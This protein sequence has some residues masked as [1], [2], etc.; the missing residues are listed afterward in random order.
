MRERKNQTNLRKTG[1]TLPSIPF[2][3][4][5]VQFC[6]AVIFDTNN[7]VGNVILNRLHCLTG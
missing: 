1:L 7:S 2:F 5:L 6:F 3:I 4:V